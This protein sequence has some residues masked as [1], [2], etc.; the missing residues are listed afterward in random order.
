MHDDNDDNAVRH[1]IVITKIKK[2][3]RLM[4]VD[5]Q[6]DLVGQLCYYDDDDYDGGGGD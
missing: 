6:K 3:I 2:W 5:S 1:Y 4:P